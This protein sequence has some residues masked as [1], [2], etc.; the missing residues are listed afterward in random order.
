MGIFF[1][2]CPKCHK[3]NIGIFQKACWRCENSHLFLFKYNDKVKITD[4]FYKGNTGKI[5]KESWGADCDFTWFNGYKVK[6]DNDTTVT[7][8]TKCLVKD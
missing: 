2:E 7:I 1:K 4:G 3:D 6:I 5:L 8:K